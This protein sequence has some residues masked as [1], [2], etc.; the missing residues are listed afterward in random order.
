MECQSS[1]GRNVSITCSSQTWYSCLLP[2]QDAESSRRTSRAPASTPTHCLSRDLTPRPHENEQC[3]QRPH[4]VHTTRAYG[5]GGAHCGWWLCSAESAV[6]T[7]TVCRTW[8]DRRSQSDKGTCMVSLPLIGTTISTKDFP[9]VRYCSA[10]SGM[11]RPV[12]QT[13]T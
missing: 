4:V 3:D 11:L 13:G 5:D 1:K 6:L 7:D 12:N 8:K 2:G 10:F 9:H